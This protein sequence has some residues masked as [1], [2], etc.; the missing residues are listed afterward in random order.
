MGDLAKGDVGKAGGNRLRWGEEK[1]LEQEF[2]LGQAEQA[3]TR[4]EGGG[5]TR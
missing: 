4:E 1:R 5:R 2:C 3:W